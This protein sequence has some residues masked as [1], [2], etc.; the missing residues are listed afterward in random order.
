MSSKDPAHLI[1]GDA[2]RALCELPDESADALITDPPYSSGATT[3]RGRAADPQEKYVHHGTLH[4]FPT[5]EGDNRDG[6]SWRFWA[7]LWLTEA[8]RVLRPGGYAL[9]FTDW[10]QLP[11]ASDA[12]QAAAFAWR[13]LVVWDKTEGSRAPHTGYFRHQSEFV[14]WGTKGR[15][16]RG[17]GPFPGVFRIAIKHSDKHHLAGKPTALMRELVRV[18]PEGGLVVDPFMGSGTTGVAA[19]QAGRRFIGVEISR[20]YFDVATERIGKRGKA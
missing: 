20:E 8:Y 12:L 10:R 18:V 6:R 5:F 17:S 15:C 14:L 19:L 1:H 7:T 3:S 9:V 4:R 11:M 2:I 16:P 13:G